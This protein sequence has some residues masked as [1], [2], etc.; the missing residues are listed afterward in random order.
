MRDLVE[1]VIAEVMRHD[2]PPQ[3]AASS[4]AP[5]RDTGRFARALEVARGQRD[6]PAPK[7]SSDAAPNTKTAPNADAPDPRHPDWRLWKASRAFEAMLVQQM[8][9]AMRQ[10]VPHSRLLHAGFAEDVQGSMFD[11][12]VAQA[13]TR[14]GGLGIAEAI[15]RQVGRARGDAAQDSASHADNGETAATLFRARRGG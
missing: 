12:A 10:T 6:Q 1:T 8:L 9:D 2:P 11:Q 15:Y 13:V 14:Q 5:R 7:A 4:P 3:R